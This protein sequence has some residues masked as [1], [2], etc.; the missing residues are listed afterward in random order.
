MVGLG[1]DLAAGVMLVRLSAK[2]VEAGHGPDEIAPVGETGAV[3]VVVMR[4]PLHAHSAAQDN[5][6]EIRRT[7]CLLL[8]SIMLVYPLQYRGAIR[9]IGHPAQITSECDGPCERRRAL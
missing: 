2:G 7:L 6:I 5:R 4:A 9:R 8:L 3:I 1:V